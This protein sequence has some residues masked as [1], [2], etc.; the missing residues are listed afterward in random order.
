MCSP[1]VEYQNVNP[2]TQVALFSSCIHNCE[3]LKNITWNIYQGLMSSLGNNVQWE[4]F[5]PRINSSNDYFFGS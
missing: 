4:T 3:S 2:S 5:S 1:N